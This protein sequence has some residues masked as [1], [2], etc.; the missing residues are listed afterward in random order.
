MATAADRKAPDERCVECGGALDAAGH[1]LFANEKL[2]SSA[3]AFMRSIRSGT[4]RCAT[5]V[6]AV[7]TWTL[8]GPVVSK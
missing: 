8:R 1:W 7:R 5:Y 6:P 4:S 2:C 3:C